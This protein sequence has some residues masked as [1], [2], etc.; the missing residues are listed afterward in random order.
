MSVRLPARL[1]VAT[2]FLSLLLAG[3][4]LAHHSWGAYDL[5]KV[6]TLKG[7]VHRFNW[8][9]PHISLEVNVKQAS[10]TVQTWATGGPSPSRMSRGGWDRD[11]VKPGDPITVFGN[12]SKDGSPK[13]RLGKVLLA[14]GQ[15]LIVY[16]NR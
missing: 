13:M 11:T 8:S 2:S 3:P 7:T 6:V 10:G 9:N 5:N 14:S 15:E 12:P 1:F 16:G 4:I